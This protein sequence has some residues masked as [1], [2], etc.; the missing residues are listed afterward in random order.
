MLVSVD[1]LNDPS[2]ACSV[3]CETCKRDSRKI[4]VRLKRSNVIRRWR[5]DSQKQEEEES[6][7]AVGWVAITRRGGDK[8]G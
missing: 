6:A 3:G 4:G 8:K 5:E 1:D 7:R 2:L